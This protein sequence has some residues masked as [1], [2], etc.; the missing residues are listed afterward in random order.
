MAAPAAFLPACGTLGAPSSFSRPVQVALD[1]EWLS[2]PARHTQVG[3]THLELIQDVGRGSGVWVK[4][5]LS[6]GQQPGR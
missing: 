1:A 4:A 2:F 6:G 3:T 5:F